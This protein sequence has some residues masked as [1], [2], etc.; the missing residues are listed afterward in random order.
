MTKII[1]WTAIEPGV[2]IIVTCL[3]TLTSFIKFFGIKSFV[4]S[5]QSGR[6]KSES[7]G[8]VDCSAE[9]KTNISYKSWNRLGSLGED[10][11][12]NGTPQVESNIELGDIERA[13]VPR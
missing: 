1:T 11:L 10:C 7:Q 5:L 3:P 13:V 8:K 4:T 12:D 2:S 9:R 6:Q